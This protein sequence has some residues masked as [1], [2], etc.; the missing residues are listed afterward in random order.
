M[1]LWVL[2]HACWWWWPVVTTVHLF[3]KRPSLTV[4][5]CVGVGYIFQE[6]RAPGGN[7][8]WHR[9]QTQRRLPAS[10]EVQRS[11]SRGR[12]GPWPTGLIAGVTELVWARPNAVWEDPDLVKRARCQCTRDHRQRD[13]RVSGGPPASGTR[14]RARVY[15]DSRSALVCRESSV[16][17]D[18]HCGD[19]TY[20]W[21]DT[22]LDKAQR[23]ARGRTTPRHYNIITCIICSSYIALFPC[24][25]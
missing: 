11:L 18:P 9:T 17:C 7:T 12:V 13:S 2:L 16:K 24:R 8:Q 22:P 5:A 20:A 23:V 10:L 1:P 21:P 15:R 14:A 6:L 3:N 19:H 25:S 4:C